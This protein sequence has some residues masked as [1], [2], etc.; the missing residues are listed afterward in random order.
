MKQTQRHEIF[1]RHSSQAPTS[2]ETVANLEVNNN[3]V[4][5]SLKGSGGICGVFL[6]C[7]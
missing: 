7:S 4:R 2:V 3:R 1:Q 6:V 5:S